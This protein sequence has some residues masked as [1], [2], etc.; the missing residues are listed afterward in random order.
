MKTNKNLFAVVYK[1]IIQQKYDMDAS[2][3]N[4]R[5]CMNGFFIRRVC[6]T[7]ISLNT[8]PTEPEQVSRCLRMWRAFCNFCL[9]GTSGKHF[10]V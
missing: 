8:K 6:Q 2:K 1:N 3:I 10:A 9:C 4:S 5:Q 7:P